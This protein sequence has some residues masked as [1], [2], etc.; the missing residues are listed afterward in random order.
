MYYTIKAT[1]T[2]DAGEELKKFNETY[3]VIGD[4]TIDATNKAK[5]YLK[6]LMSTHS[7]EITGV[8]V[9]NYVDIIGYEKDKTIPQPPVMG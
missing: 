6:T 8:N 3:L 1:V 9:V 4:D 5:A 2:K 7:A